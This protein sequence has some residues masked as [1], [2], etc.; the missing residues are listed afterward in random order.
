MKNKLQFK[1][2]AA[3]V[4]GACLLVGLLSGCGAK[5]EPEDPT[6][7]APTETTAAPTETTAAPTSAVPADAPATKAELD[8]FEEMFTI[9]ASFAYCVNEDLNYDSAAENALPVALYSIRN[10][11]YDLYGYYREKKGWQG[12]E[13][14]VSDSEYDE[15]AERYVFKT[16]DPLGLVNWYYY[17]QIP[18]KRVDWI[19]ENILNVQPDHNFNSFQREDREKYSCLQC[20]YHDGSYYYGLGDG[21]DAGVLARVDS[22]TLGADGMYTLRVSLVS[23]GDDSVLE[24]CTVKAKLRDVDGSREWQIH[25]V[26]A[27]GLT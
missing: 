4:L 2:P 21:G 25:T 23:Y 13:K 18:A 11:W 16:P 27:N 24:T 22:E 6:Q 3:L 20:Y 7:T 9:F 26:Q 5:P 8:D 1:R 15:A 17:E 19:L 14:F 12:E 10:V